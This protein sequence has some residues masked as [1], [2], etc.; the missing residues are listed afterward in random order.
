MFS[1]HCSHST[2]PLWL[3]SFALALLASANPAVAAERQRAAPGLDNPALLAGGQEY[4]SGVILLKLVHPLENGGVAKA[5]G[6]G[7]LDAL[8]ARHGV[9]RLEPLVP[10]D[11]SARTAGAGLSRL[12]RVQFSS[13]ADALEVARAFAASADVE[14]AEPQFVYPLA[15]LSNDPL[16]AVEQS[17]YF[18][19]MSFPAAYDDTR[20]NEGGVV[21]AIVDGGSEWQHPDLAAN[22]WTNPGETA[23]GQDDDGNGYVDDVHGWNFANGSNDPTGLVQTPSAAG[24]GTHVAGIACAVSDNA[25]GVAGA[26]WN[27]RFMP[28]C[29]AHPTLDNA[30]AFGYQGILYA[31][32]NGADVVNCSW[33][34]QG[35]PSYFEREVIEYAREHGVVV[36]AAAGNNGSAADFYP[37]MYPHVLAVANVNNSDQ[38][39]ASSNYGTWVDVSAQGTN[40]HSTYRGGNYLDLNGTSMAS[41]HVA[42]ACA[43][44]KTKWPSYRA[45]QVR[46]RV[47]VT[48]TNIDALNPGFAGQLGYGRIHVA[49]ALAKVTPAIRIQSVTYDTPDGDAVIEPGETIAVHVRVINYLDAATNATFTL[50][51]TSSYASATTNN[52]AVANLGTLEETGLDFAVRFTAAAPVNHLVTFVLNISTGSPVYTDVDRFELRVLPIITTHDANHVLTTVTSVGKLGFGEKAGG[53]GKDGV[54]FLFAGSPNLLFEG[55][56][57]IGTGMATISDG[58]RG[59]NPSVADDDF[60][61][62]AN[63]TPALSETHPVYD[64]FAVAAF[65]DAGATTAL[66]LHVR[67]ESWEISAPPYD[68]FV[69]LRYA[70]RNQSAATLDGIRVGWFFDWDVDGSNYETNRTGFDASRGLGYVYDDGAGP[71]VFVGVRTLTAPGTTSYR[72]IWNDESDA[73]NP[74]WGVYDGFIDAEKWECL[75]AGIVN[76]S[77][78]PADISQALA[79]G[80]F[81]IAPGDSIVVAFAILGGSDLADL[82]Q[83]ADVAQSAWDQPVDSEITSVPRR[84]WLAQNVPNP[85]NPTT[86]IVFDLPQLAA[87]ELGVYSVSGKLVRTLAGERLQP[88]TH[89]VTWDGRDRSGRRAPSGTYFYRLTVDGRSFTR[90]MQML[91]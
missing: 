2:R 35:N 11:G 34:G 47:R 7:A 80:P 51:E 14:Y 70:I 88:G 25:S 10:A 50:G 30:I 75:S 38:K 20:G 55:A 46:E 72:G 8:C 42:A 36:V 16:Y 77:V 71:E 15:A 78:G 83:N 21:I 49:Q 73:D 27:A 66:G 5:S 43:L 91:K 81:T 53:N 19:K 65:T 61:T 85:F 52:D 57:M 24:H 12:Y 69:V 22:V 4:L 68:D 59:A 41:P 87:V 45:E 48:A 86:E 89:R 40:I 84:L 6:I 29:V 37:A 56:L 74:A 44:V 58:A 31:V 90:K 60:V 79:T 18:D 39:I 13:G 76:P 26:S 67:Q 3:V 9:E 82:Q 54:G 23:N 33:G 17:P 32:D 1:C 64:Q 63:G 62:A 28:V